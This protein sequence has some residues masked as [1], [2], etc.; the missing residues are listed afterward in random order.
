[1]ICSCP[2]RRQRTRIRR[3]LAACLVVATCAPALPAAAQQTSRPQPDR[4]HHGAP[5]HAVSASEK[6]EHSTPTHH[7]ELRHHRDHPPVVQPHPAV[8]RHAVRRSAATAAAAAG[9]AAATAAVPPPSASS[10]PAEQATTP[11]RPP[12]DPAKGTET[13]LPLPRFAALRSDDV[14]L[15]VGPGQ[16][17]PI[18]WVY[19]RHDLPVEIQREF[20]VWR[21]VSDSDGVKGWVHQAT[22]VGRRTAVVQGAER[23]LRGSPNDTASPVAMLKPGVVAR[24]LHCDANSEWC[25]L[26]VQGYRG[27]LKRTEFWGTYPGEAVN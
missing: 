9:A 21:L 22:L 5:H 13:G 4:H 1:M 20:D 6:R 3:V 10:A 18:E 26:Q 23:P 8:P 25:Q 7:R 17:Y 16:R 27:Y 14:Y 19:K 12:V 24:I 15:R 2:V 11:A